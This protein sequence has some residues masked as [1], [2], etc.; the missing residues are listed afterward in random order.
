[1]L[2]ATAKI[3]LITPMQRGDFVYVN[4]FKN[5]AWGSYKEKNGQQLEQFADAVVNIGN[6][7][8]FPVIDLY[9]NSKLKI[10]ALVKFKRLK[11]PATGAYEDYKYPAYTDVSFNPQ[12]DEYPYPPAAIGMT[13]DGLHPSDKGNALIADK[14]MK[15]FKKILK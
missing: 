15:A 3:I 7:E 12:T 1:M 6:K 8:G 11:N 13:F 4:N 10:K 14:L 9:H 2:N 5:N